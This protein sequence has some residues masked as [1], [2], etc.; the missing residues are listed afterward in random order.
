[1]SLDGSW[2]NWIFPKKKD[3]MYCETVWA[4]PKGVDEEII[5]HDKEWEEGLF[6]LG[7][8]FNVA[9]RIPLWCYAK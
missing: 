8:E 3:R 6:N 7:R 2:K 1:M 5:K 4:V 9:I